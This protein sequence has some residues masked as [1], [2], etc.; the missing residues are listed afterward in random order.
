MFV[1]GIDSQIDGFKVVLT[2]W[3]G[4]LLKSPVEK[5]IVRCHDLGAWTHHQ[6]WTNHQ[7]SLVFAFGNPTWILQNQ[8]FVDDRPVPNGVFHI[9]ACFPGGT[10]GSMLVPNG[11]I[12]CEAIEQRATR[13]GVQVLSASWPLIL[14]WR[15]IFIELIGGLVL[16]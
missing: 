12:P 13:E 10:S 6:W 1:F 7:W 4:C 9:S 14:I 16:T 3:P 2:T 11:P 15:F 8:Q 5:L